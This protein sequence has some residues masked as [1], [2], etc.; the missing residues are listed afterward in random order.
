MRAKIGD[1]LRDLRLAN[2]QTLK[3]MADTL[4]V[5]SAFLSAVE[6]GKKK[7]PE[8]WYG[9]LSE[10]YSLSSSQFDELKTAVDESS[11]TIKLNLT[12]VNSSNRK[13]A[14]TFARSFNGLSKRET[15]EILKILER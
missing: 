6:N 13:L 4:D 8:K 14:I 10:K 7:M 11:T 9:V 3:Q 12:N 1:Y 2:S 15:N 5:S